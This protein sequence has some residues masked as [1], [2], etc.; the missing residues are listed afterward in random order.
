MPDAG[1]LTLTRPTT[2]SRSDMSG[3]GA[4]ALTR[5]TTLSRSDMPGAGALTLT[6]PTTQ[7]APVG[8]VS[9]AHPPRKTN[10]TEGG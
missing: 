10:S 1:A 7:A 9:E 8:R 5:P 4:L 6:R 2:L 3:A